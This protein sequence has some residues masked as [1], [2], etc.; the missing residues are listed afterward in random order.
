VVAVAAV[1]VIVVVA[2]A[3]VVVTVAEAAAE[4][5]VVTVVAAVEIEIEDPAQVVQETDVIKIDLF[6]T[7]KP[8][9]PGLC[10]L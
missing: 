3:E 2:A 4:V 1:A 9:Y 8:G 6:N 7:N 10:Y 5:V